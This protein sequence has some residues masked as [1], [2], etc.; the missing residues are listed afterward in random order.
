M[1]VVFDASFLVPLLDPQINGAGEV[2]K[3]IEFLL[4][5]LE[6]AK[7]KIFIPTPA[8]SEVLIGAGDAAPQYLDIIN[9]S[10]RFEVVPFG[11]RAA[12]E[13]AAAHREAIGAGNK[14]EG[15]ASWAKVKFDRQIVAIAKV[16]GVDRIYSNDAD[17]V[18]FA[19][20]DAIAVI[21]IEQLPLPPTGQQG[22][23]PLEQ[24]ALH[25]MASEHLCGPRQI[26]SSVVGQ[27]T[28]ATA[29]AF[30]RR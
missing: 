18:R 5:T 23:L 3:R 28:V 8:L 4:K 7:A 29:H 6:I 16:E 19:A 15:S 17:I 11:E 22:T 13:A 2:D 1:F 24:D 27:P 20:R 30:A 10:S 26:V 25:F 14:K 12:V 9:K 21:T